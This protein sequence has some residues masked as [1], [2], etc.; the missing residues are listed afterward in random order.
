MTIHAAKINTSRRLLRVLAMLADGK[1]YTTREIQLNAEVCNAHTC[2][3]ELRANGYE[4]E[5]T[6]IRK[7]VYQYRLIGM[8]EGFN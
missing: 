5:C 3:S 7:G 8:R 4:I 6:C 1:A 2:V